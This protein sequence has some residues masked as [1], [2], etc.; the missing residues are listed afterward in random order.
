[1]IVKKQTGPEQLPEV[2]IILGPIKAKYCGHVVQRGADVAEVHVRLDLLGQ[3]ADDGLVQGR[4]LCHQVEKSRQ[5]RNFFHVAFHC[6]K[7]QAL[8]VGVVAVEMDECFLAGC[9]FCD[10]FEDN[11]PKPS[12]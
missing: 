12:P 2:E 10:C 9:A 7:Q 5:L 6:L 11:E 1:M 8:V 3:E 4:M